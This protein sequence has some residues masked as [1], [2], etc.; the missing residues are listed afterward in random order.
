MMR[1]LLS[2]GNY[3]PRYFTSY[4]ALSPTYDLLIV[5]RFGAVVLFAAN[6]DEVDAGG[7]IISDQNEI[8][9]LQRHARLL[10]AHTTPLIIPYSNLQDDPYAMMIHSAEARRGGR[11]ALKDGFSTTTQP[12]EWFT[13]SP[14]K[15][16]PTTYSLETW[17]QITSTRGERIAASSV[18]WRSTISMISV[19]C[20]I[21]KFTFEG[22]YP[23]DDPLN[24]RRQPLH[25]HL[26]HLR[27]AS[28]AQQASTLSSR[29]R[30][31]LA[32]ES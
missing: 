31:R 3:F 17:E 20:A 26:E 21:E 18:I 30:S 8:S 13:D 24:H 1:A 15:R 5:P 10:A 27:N 23:T 25:L 9:L 12:E 4:G 29:T 14:I 11:L 6:R 22:I 2:M 16:M 28:I 7:I 19:Q 32:G